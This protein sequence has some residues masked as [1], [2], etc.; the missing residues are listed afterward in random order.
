MKRDFLAVTDFNESEVRETIRL[1]V[2][3]KKK[4]GQVLDVLKGKTVACIF[5][6]PSL[7]TRIS[8]EVGI[9]E[10]GGHSLYITDQEIQLGVRESIHDVAKVFSR[11]VGMIEIRTFSHDNVVQLA[12]HADVPVI[13]G[14]TDLSHPCQIMGDMQ[15]IIEHKGKIDHMKIAYL[16]D[17]NNVANSWLEAATV[18]PFDLRIGTRNETMPDSAITE[19]AK[20]AGKSKITITED[21]HEAVRNADVIYTDVWASMGQKD[22]F[23]SKA[24]LLMDFQVNTHLLAGANQAC[25]VMHCLPA[26][27][28]REI[29][30][31]VIDG[32]HSVVFDQAENRLHAQKA[33]MVKLAQWMH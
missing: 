10:L 24:D 8:F 29:T 27:R 9:H 3:L 4:K 30:D 2:D 21:P 22:Q 5:H 1:A 31:D 19:R 12:K 18:L 15:T 23:Q 33:I 17:G 16:G 13:N 14:L 32:P 11:L 7:R 28:G 25:I 6:K 26:E 20:K